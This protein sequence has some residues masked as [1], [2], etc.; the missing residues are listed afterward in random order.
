MFKFF[1]IFSFSFFFFG[2]EFICHASA[3]RSISG[4]CIST[5]HTASGQ[6]LHLYGGVLRRSVRG[7]E[8]GLPITPEELEKVFPKGSLMAFCFSSG[9]E[10]DRCMIDL[11]SRRAIASFTMVCPVVGY[12]FY[13]KKAHGEAVVKEHS[14]KMKRRKFVKD[15]A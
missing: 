12:L 11:C 6:D 1:I 10:A 7:L 15:E 9:V 5:V 2:Q 3:R 8:E 4:G 13:L 14:E